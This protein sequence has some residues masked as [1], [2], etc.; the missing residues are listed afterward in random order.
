M[1]GF[2]AFLGGGAKHRE[3]PNFVILFLFSSHEKATET[4]CIGRV[5]TRLVQTRSSLLQ[6]FLAFALE[7]SA[8]ILL[9]FF[10]LLL[11]RDNYRNASYPR[12]QLGLGR[13]STITLAILAVVKTTLRTTRPRCR[14]FAVL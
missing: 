4:L 8:L 1:G 6:S 12:T 3:N 9:K 11:V 13:S 5:Q 10:N 2:G 7:F 14:P